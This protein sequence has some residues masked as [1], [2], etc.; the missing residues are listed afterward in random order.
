VLPI[1]VTVWFLYYAFTTVDSL[2][3]K[4]LLLFFRKSVLL[5]REKYVFG[6]SL[7]VLLLL[8][9]GIGWLVSNIFGRII[10]RLVDRFFE[11][12]PLVNKIYHFMKQVTGS[13]GI[14]GI[15]PF[16][17]VVLIDYPRPGL[18][19]L[20]FVSNEF[21]NGLSGDQAS[22]GKLAVFIP[23]SPN[24]TSGFVV[25]VDESECIPLDMTVEEGLKFIVT[26]GALYSDDTG[27]RQL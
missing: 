20:G 3:Y 14:E 18:K 19:A 24:P 27:R 26:G 16:K 12:V 13:F 5:D 4:F 17:Q 1:G 10:T 6:F 25:L 9:T 11:T 2:S 15:S 21:P 22:R 7:L 8:L 23:T